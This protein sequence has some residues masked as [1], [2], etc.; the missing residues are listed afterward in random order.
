MTTIIETSDGTR[1][2][3]LH[4]TVPINLALEYELGKSHNNI[5][6]SQDILGEMLLAYQHV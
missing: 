6:L 1:A 2:Q 5:S 3:A 4:T